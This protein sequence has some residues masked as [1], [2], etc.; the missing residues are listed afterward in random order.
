MDGHGWSSCRGPRELL[1]SH[2]RRVPAWDV[3]RRCPTVG[4]AGRARRQAA[5]APCIRL[6]SAAP[7]SIVR[8]RRLVAD[9]THQR[10]GPYFRGWS[11]ATGTHVAQ[12]SAGVAG[13]AAGRAKGAIDE[14]TRRA[15]RRGPRCPCRA[16][17]RLGGSRHQ[18]CLQRVRGLAIRGSS[19]SSRPPSLAAWFAGLIGGMTAVIVTV[20]LNA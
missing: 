20:T 11:I 19:C 16:I 17:H 12:E 1:H 13:Q 3:A 4:G 14:R 18:G 15:V 6:L 2:G 9:G 5:L 8:H 10:G 7:A